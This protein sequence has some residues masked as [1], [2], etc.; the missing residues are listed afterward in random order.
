[1]TSRNYKEYIEKVHR[2]HINYPF[3]NLKH[4]NILGCEEFKKK[5][6]EKCGLKKQENRNI[7]LPLSEK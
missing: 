4:S 1:M 6:E 5:I 7:M 3:K 2:K